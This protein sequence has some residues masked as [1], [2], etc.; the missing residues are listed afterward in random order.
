M[1]KILAIIYAITGIPLAMIVLAELG[2]KFTIGLKLLIVVIRRF[3]QPRK[4]RKV[5]QRR[6]KLKGNGSDPEEGRVIDGTSVEREEERNKEGKAKKMEK[7]KEVSSDEYSKDLKGNDE[8]KN[9]DTNG[10][11]E[12][13]I[14]GDEEST[15]QQEDD[16][17]KVNIVFGVEIDEEFNL[18]PSVALAIMV[19]YLLIGCLMYPAW[20]NWTFLDSFY[21][22][23]ISMSTI[24]FGDILPAHPKFFLV[25]GI[26][27]FIGLSLISMCINVGIEFFTKTMKKAKK[28][29]HE[30]KDKMAVISK[31][32]MSEVGKHIDKAKDKMSEVTDK[33]AEVTDKMAE[34]VKKNVENVQR[35]IQTKTGSKSSTP[36]S[37]PKRS[38]SDD[39]ER[40]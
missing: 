5:L 14:K 4:F 18:P 31:E 33:M 40:T 37:S 28:K 20:E 6:F 32:K 13:N 8:D 15:E 25:S 1:G 27:L 12:D 36:V 39:V 38:K 24:G 17:Q 35:E 11:S 7:Y 34:E 2:R 16:R 29:M 21:F 3:Y 9:I 26:Y 23:F 22:V 10:V 30:A 19:I